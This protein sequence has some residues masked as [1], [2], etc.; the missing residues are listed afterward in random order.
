MARVT[1]GSMV[2]S[3]VHCTMV[4][5]DDESVIRVWYRLYRRE[6]RTCHTKGSVVGRSGHLACGH[7]VVRARRHA[8]DA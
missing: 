6:A 5:V 8:R 1:K 7:L 2:R 3:R 4:C